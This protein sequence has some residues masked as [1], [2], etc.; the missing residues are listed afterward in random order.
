[1][2]HIVTIADYCYR[3]LKNQIQ[4]SPDGLDRQKAKKTKENSINKSAESRNRELLRNKKD[5]FGM[6]DVIKFC[7]RSYKIVIVARETA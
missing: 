1:M 6:F 4:V 5:Q 2:R 7:G 3:Q